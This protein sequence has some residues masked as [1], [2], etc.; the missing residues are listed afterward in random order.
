MRKR[1]LILAAAAAVAAGCSSEQGP[2]AGELAVRLATPSSGNRAA[3][4]VVIGPAG[5]VTAP[6]GSGYRVFT[7]TT[8]TD[9]T[10]VVAVAPVG[11]ALLAGDLVRIA[12]NDTRQ[13]KKYSARVLALAASNYFPLDTT[14]VSLSVVRP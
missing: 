6:A 13:Y 2:V 9:T 7:R 14:G 12:V 5:A 10:R 3:L 8:G 11:S 1:L 4:F